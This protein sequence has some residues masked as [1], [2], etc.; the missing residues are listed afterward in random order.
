MS[1]NILITGATGY[2]GGTLLRALVSAR[3]VPPS[4]IW[5]IV[6]SDTQAESVEHLQV[7]AVQ[8]ALTDEGGI[9]RAILDNGIDIVIHTVSVVDP[10]LAASLLNALKARK[11]STNRPVYFIYNSGVSAFADKTGWPYGVAKETDDLYELQKGL[12][13]PNPVRQT[14]VAIHATADKYGIALYTVVPPLVYG[15]GTGTGNKISVQIP[16]LIRAAIANK[17]VHRFAENSKWPAV[18]VTDLADYYTRLIQGIVEERGIPAGKRGYYLVSAH[19]FNWHELLSGLAKDLFTRGLVATDD[20]TVWPNEDVKT[21]SLGLPSPYSDIAWN[22]NAAVSSHHDKEL[23]WKPK[24]DYERL[25]RDIGEEVDAVL[26]AGTD[27][28]DLAGLLSK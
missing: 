26:E 28:R 14:D 22:S 10:T 8:V 27:V 4:S 23:G 21:K 1:P 24:W 18:H 13:V 2:I 5:A 20:V 12:T 3:V 19:T 7:N 16:T 9:Q 15:K 11:A 17:E 25:L 6:R